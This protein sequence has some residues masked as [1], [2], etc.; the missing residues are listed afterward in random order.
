MMR[1]LSFLL[2]CVLTLR[3]QVPDLTDRLQQ[4]ALAYAEAQAVGLVGTISLRVLHAPTLP[5]LP[6]GEVRFEPTHV[7]KQDFAGPFFV[8]FRIFVNGHVSGSAR[9]DLEGRWVGKL[10]RT[11]SALARKAVPTEDQLEEVPF[12]GVPPPGAITE[13]PAGFQMKI[14]VSTG[15]ILCR[16]DLQPILVISSGD[17]VRLELVCGTLVVASESVARTSGALGE[18]IRL[19]LPNSRRNLQAVITGPGEAR[20]EWAQPG[21]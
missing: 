4:E 7:S 18:K 21:S 15:K 11:R 17:P 8:A 14:P 6:E 3:A 10:L 16:S 20:I 5:R 9:V 2:L 12:E 13:F 19:E 1:L